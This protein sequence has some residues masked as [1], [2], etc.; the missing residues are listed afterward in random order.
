MYFECKINIKAEQIVNIEHF[1]YIV[2][3]TI[4]NKKITTEDKEI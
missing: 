3:W 1:K 4:Y 2:V